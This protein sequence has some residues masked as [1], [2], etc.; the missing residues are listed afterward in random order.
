MEKCKFCEAEL[1]EEST[2]CPQCGK[3]NAELT[4]EE[5]TLTE[6]PADE[7]ETATDAE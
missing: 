6:A 7:A 4:E 1:E 5:Q 2:L 3:D